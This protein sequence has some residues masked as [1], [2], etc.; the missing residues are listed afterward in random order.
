VPFFRS[1]GPSQCLP[2]PLLLARWLHCFS[3]SYCS[4]RVVRSR[5][6]VVPSIGVCGS[7]CYAACV[8]DGSSSVLDTDKSSQRRPVT[9]P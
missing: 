8:F 2:L 4:L 1:F 7:L 9:D 5:L 3:L 6:A